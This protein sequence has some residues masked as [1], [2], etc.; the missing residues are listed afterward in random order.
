MLKYCYDPV[1]HLSLK[2]WSPHLLFE[3]DFDSG[4][5]YQEVSE[6]KRLT[7]VEQQQKQREIVHC[8]TR[9]LVQMIKDS[10]VY[11]CV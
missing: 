3:Q 4:S 10:S 6:R 11:F 2:S 8:W 5:S 9:S 7:S 1:P